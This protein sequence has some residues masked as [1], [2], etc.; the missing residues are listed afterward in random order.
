MTR[1]EMG[2]LAAAGEPIKSKSRI[3]LRSITHPNTADTPSIAI[4][5]TIALPPAVRS[6]IDG[7]WTIVVAGRTVIIR[8]VG[9][10]S[11]K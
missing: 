5:E 8:T 7:A 11:A 6:V 4:P 2:P 3:N 9:N 1:N 10:S